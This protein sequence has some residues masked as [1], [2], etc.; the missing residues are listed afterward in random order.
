MF[1]IHIYIALYDLFL[2]YLRDLHIN[3]LHLHAHIFLYIHTY[4]LHSLA[5][6]V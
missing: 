5:G 4:L 3:L 2:I 1:Y 6:I